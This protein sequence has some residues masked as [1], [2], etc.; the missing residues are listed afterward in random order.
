MIW[1]ISAGAGQMLIINALI[2][3]HFH[4]QESRG[5]QIIAALCDHSAITA[6]SQ[7]SRRRVGIADRK[8]FACPESFLR[9]YKISH[10]MKTKHQLKSE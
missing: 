6:E 5:G 10:K 2:V 3:A 1:V 8:V 4:F 9:F 7:K